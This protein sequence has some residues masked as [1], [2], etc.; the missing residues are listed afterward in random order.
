MCSPG[1]F[2]HIAPQPGTNPGWD[3]YQQQ[4]TQQNPNLSYLG[5]LMAG[6][7]PG[8][9]PLGNVGNSMGVTTYAQ[10]PNGPAITGP[11]QSGNMLS[12]SPLNAIPNK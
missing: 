6:S 3:Q 9:M 1:L 2:Q 5:Y 11:G 10:P 12:S 7:P 4:N 8:T